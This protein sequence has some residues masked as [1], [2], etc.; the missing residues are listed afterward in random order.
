M[1]LLQVL[2]DFAGSTSIH[3]LTF[4]VQPQLSV[5]KR[6]AWAV[7]FLA[8]L[9]YAGRQLNIS[10]IC[11]FGSFMLIIPVLKY[12]TILHLQLCHNF[13]LLIMPILGLVLTP[14]IFLQQT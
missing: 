14:N 2:K 13:G 11:K 12:I 10:V 1:G 5:A 6:G 8:A 9:I 4:M 3:G 7:V